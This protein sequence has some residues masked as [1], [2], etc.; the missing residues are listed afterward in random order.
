[1]FNPVQASDEIK[2]SYIDYI[3]TTFDMADKEYAALFRKEL[4]KEGM[5]AKGPYLDIGGSYET[6]HTLQELMESGEAS[7]LFADLEPIPEK[8]RELKLNRPLYLHQEKALK[9][10]SSGQN[11]VVTT[12]TGSGKTESFLLPIIQHVLSQMEHGELNSGVRAIII[13]PMNALANDQIKRM[14]ALLKNF[15][16]IRFGIYNGNTKHGR[17]EALHEYRKTHKDASGNPMDPLPN[18]L[19]SRE[20]MQDDPPHILITNYSMLEYMMLRPKDDAVFSGAK[21]KYIVLDEAHIYKGAT[22]MET[23]LLMR[24][25]RARISQPKAVQYILTSATLGGR[26]ADKEILQFAEKLTGVPFEANGIIRSVEK[27]PSMVE[28]RIVDPQLFTELCTMPD[29]VGETLSRYE[30]DFC[31]EGNAE[32]KLYWLCL[33]MAQFSKLREVAEKP[34]TVSELH[35]ALQKVSPNM[36][37]NHVVEF[38]QV[39]ARAELNGANLIKPRYHFFARALEGAYISLVSPKELY[40]DRQHTRTLPTGEANAVFEAAICSDC[41]RLAV[42]GRTEDGKLIQSARKSDE[43]PVEFYLLKNSKDGELFTDDEYLDEEDDDGQQ[44]YVLCPVCGAISTKADQTYSSLCEH[45]SSAYVEV[46]LISPNKSKRPKCPACGFGAFR[47]FYLGSEAATAVLG[48]ELFEQLPAED[49]KEV[50]VN[51]AGKGGLFARASKKIVRQERQRQFLC[52]SDSRSEA[53][54]FATYMERSYQEFLRRRGIWHTTEQLVARGISR[55]SVKEFVGEL[56]RYFEDNRSFAEWDSGP[57]GHTAESRENAWV[58]ILNEMFNARRATSLVSMGKLAFAYRKNEGLAEV[59]SGI[60]N[61]LPITDAGALLEQLAMDAVFSGA[62]NAGS[63]LKLTDAEREYIFFSPYEKKLIKLKTGADSKKTNLSGWCG[64]IRTNGKGGYYPNTRISRLTGALSITEEAADGVLGDYWDGVFSPETEQF[65]LDANDFDIL[66]GGTDA[67]H[68]FRCK[69]CGKVTPYNVKGMCASVKC[70]GE[71]EA[72]EPLEH[73]DGNHYARLYQSDKMQPLFIKEH[74][75]QLAKDQQTKYQEAFV[76]KNINALSCSTTFEMGVDVGSLETV[77]LRDVPPSPANYV[78]RAGRAGR[79][80]GSA[81]FVMTYAKLSSHDFTYYD[82]PEKMISGKISA[83]VFEVENEKIL[84]RHVFAVAIS[85][86]LAEN[87]DVYDGDNQTVLLN[88]GGYE[89]LREFLSKRPEE[90]KSLLERSIPIS[91]HHRLGIDDWSWTDHLCGEKGLLEL[92]VNDFRETVADMEKQQKRAHKEHNDEEAGK[93]QRT[94]RNYRCAREDNVG[95]KSLI[96]FLVRNN[97][98]PKY[99]FPVDTVELL[100]RANNTGDDKDLQLARDLQM[101]IA[102]YAPGAQIVADGKLYTSRYI[103]KTPGNNTG[104]TWEIGY[105]CRECPTCGQ[106]NFTKEPVIGSREC[107]SCHTPIQKRRWA[108]T[109]EPRLGFCADLR[110]DPVPLHRPE[111]D[112]KTDDIYVGDPQR[113]VLQEQEFIVNSIP[114]KIASTSNDSLVV[115]GQTDFQV[116]QSCGYAHDKVIPYPHKTMRGYNCVNTEGTATKTFR[117]SHDFKT[118]VVRITFV[119]ESAGDLDTMLSV[120]YALLEGLSREIGIERTDIKGC[121]FRTY[122]NGILLYSVILYDAVAGG[123]GHVRRMVTEDGAILQRVLKRAYDVANECECGSSCYKCLRNYFN[124]KIHDQLDRVK[125]ATFLQN[126][127]GNMISA[128]TEAPAEEKGEAAASDGDAELILS[129]DFGMNMR[130]SRWESIWES[131][132]SMA[133]NKEERQLVKAIAQNA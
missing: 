18:E 54:F 33:H 53:A 60:G 73:T 64:R 38:I 110:E 123:A 7:P 12:G 126:W 39:C 100:P 61:G 51:Q 77:Y 70:D 75:A 78:Q 111:H 32:E 105:F 35:K 89:R 63:E 97:I 115:V 16:K 133:D 49:V 45:G 29:S 56:S 20:E 129:D 47:R 86:F 14:R 101:A 22:G 106:P 113:N 8:E 116:C 66:L 28:E 11:L 30:L 24:R 79:G 19:I 48:T 69:K 13:Y 119:T 17:A 81:A 104:T 27:K 131:V 37:R 2:K 124:Q 6:G 118:D 25:L 112:Y 80:K 90:L 57:V 71:L 93:W 107:V 130:D 40:L 41:G 4:E 44:D 87:S 96:S 128:P 132:A 62:I 103:R 102:D 88:E 59:I 42:V 76:N 52:F 125:A 83:P 31:P 114:L 5:A 98:L 67:V 1:M 55:I 21:L 121:L 58:A 68:F 85:A 72:Y 43:E 74:T 91:M 122:E 36:T 15:N 95:K 10:A 65:S 127:I 120:L 108:K 34:I 46:R 3:T 26:D 117:L 99:G 82:E 23:S 94:L 84:Y 9:K 109:L 92:A 50:A